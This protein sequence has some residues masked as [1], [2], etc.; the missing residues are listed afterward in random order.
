[1]YHKLY[2]YLYITSGHGKDW[3][4]QFN[5]DQNNNEI[6]SNIWPEERFTTTKA[7][8][9]QREKRQSKDIFWPESNIVLYHPTIRRLGLKAWLSIHF[10]CGSEFISYRSVNN[11]LIFLFYALG[12]KLYLSLQWASREHEVNLVDLGFSDVSTYALLEEAVVS[13]L[14]YLYLL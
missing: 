5:H 9:N 11:I 6:D 10:R 4:V 8:A 13:C 14:Y 3:L 12:R 7:C 1:M 2:I